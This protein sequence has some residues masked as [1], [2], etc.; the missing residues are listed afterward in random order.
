MT[1]D[2]PFIIMVTVLLIVVGVS[3]MFSS[4]CIDCDCLST[5]FCHNC[6]VA[7][8][9]CDECTV[10]SDEYFAGVWSCFLTWH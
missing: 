4:L 8:L 5:Y 1:D 7:V 2:A 3:N 6:V 9:Y 10:L